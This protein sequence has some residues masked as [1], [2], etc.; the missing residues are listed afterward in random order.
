MPKEHHYFI[1]ADSRNGGEMGNEHS[2][3]SCSLYIYGPM[4]CP[5]YGLTLKCHDNPRYRRTEE[6]IILGNLT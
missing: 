3:S 5:I 6:E 1:Q 4:L 2:W